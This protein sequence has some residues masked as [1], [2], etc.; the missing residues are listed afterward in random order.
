MKLHFPWPDVLKAL[1]EIK[2]ANTAAPF[3]GKGLEPG[4]LIV[5]DHGV[6]LMPNTTDGIHHKTGEKIIVYARECD[7]RSMPFDDWWDAK[8]KSWGGHDG[9]ELVNSADLRAMIALLALSEIPGRPQTIIGDLV[10][11]FA[12]MQFELSIQLTHTH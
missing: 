12:P 3:Y 1:Q 4:L 9:C 2:T 8:N 7:P 6:Y 10:I 5:G 11:D